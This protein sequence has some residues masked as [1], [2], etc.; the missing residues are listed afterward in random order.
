MNQPKSMDMKSLEI[1]SIAASAPESTGTILG[2]LGIAWGGLFA[3]LT[4]G[5]L[6]LIATLI[7]TL[8]QTGLLIVE[9]II[10]PILAARRA[11]KI[12]NTPSGD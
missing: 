5:D 2:K 8:L 4:L 1:H 3:G 12:S 10:K 11:A 9:R 7:Y 6:V